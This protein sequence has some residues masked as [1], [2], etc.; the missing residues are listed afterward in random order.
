M[1][2][3]PGSWRNW[4]GSVRC[5]PASWERPGDVDAIRELVRRAKRDGRRVRVAGSGHSFSPLVAT[6]DVLI[7][8]DRMQ[9]I[10]SLDS[11]RR[12]VTVRAGTTLRA[13]GRD[14]HAAGFALENLGG[15]DVQTVAGAI[16]TGTHGSGLGF[17]SM[18]TQVAGITLVTGDG[19][20]VDASVDK[21]PDLLHAA[22]LALGALG[23]IVS[24][25]LR[26]VPAHR[27]RL[28]TSRERIARCRE[29]LVEDARAHQHFEL[30]WFPH[31]ESAQK[32]ILDP[33][34]MDA[35]PRHRARR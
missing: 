9:G 29:R 32:R 1:S 24:V 28:Q 31:T 30:F 12:E 27:L 18:A 4:S 14:L 23:I 17:G 5:T 34:P 7:T 10:I 3:R 11:T 26:V 20:V 22:S 19:S 16:S 25:T 13:L 6:D 8:L 33:A 35:R 21:D 15:V 2:S